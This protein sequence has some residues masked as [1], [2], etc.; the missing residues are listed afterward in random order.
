[1]TTGELLLLAGIT[2]AVLVV[3]GS[4]FTEASVSIGSEGPTVTPVG[5]NDAS[6]GS[7]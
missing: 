4:R 3:L 1:M 7:P 6:A 5:T 2:F